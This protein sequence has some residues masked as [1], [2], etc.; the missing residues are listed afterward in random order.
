MSRACQ[1][2]VLQE[3]QHQQQQNTFCWI[4]EQSY[5]VAFDFLVYKVLVSTGMQSAPIIA[6]LT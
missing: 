3:Q 2:E 1:D 6:L 4:A 5:A